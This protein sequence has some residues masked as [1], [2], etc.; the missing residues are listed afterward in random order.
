MGHTMNLLQKKRL[1]NEKER[2]EHVGLIT[3]QRALAD[4]SR[5]EFKLTTK[6]SKPVISCLYAQQERIW[7]RPCR[8]PFKVKR[9]KQGET[10][11]LNKNYSSGFAGSKRDVSTSTPGCFAKKKLDNNISPMRE[12]LGTLNL[13]LNHLW[14]GWTISSADGIYVRSSLTEI[15]E[16]LRR[17]QLS[18][19]SRKIRNCYFACQKGLI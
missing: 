16:T 5:H 7:T 19:S 14:D 18:A 12:I 2:R 6:P 1:V 11:W 9:V 13:Q 4:W 10:M 17:G 3:S 8:H 15:R